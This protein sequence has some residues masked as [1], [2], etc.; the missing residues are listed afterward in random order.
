ME[1]LIY[2][3]HCFSIKGKTVYTTDRSP[4]LMEICR[5]SSASFVL[6]LRSAHLFQA[7]QLAMCLNF[8]IL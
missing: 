2:A 4:K 5:A 8:W 1:G 6:P 3:R 7:F